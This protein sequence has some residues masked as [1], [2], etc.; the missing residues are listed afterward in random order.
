MDDSS[1]AANKGPGLDKQPT[2]HPY[3]MQEIH[4]AIPKHCTQPSTLRSLGVI[5]RDLLLIFIIGCMATR[6]SSLT[7]PI[8]RF[9]AWSLYGFCQGLFF[10]GLWELAHE[11]GHRAL[12]KDKWVND[13][14]GL[15]VHSSLLVP[16]HSWRFT[17][18]THHKSTNHMDRDIAFVPQVKDPAQADKRTGTFEKAID[19]VA[20][21]PAAA[22]ATLFVHQLVAF[23]LYLTINNFALPQIRAAPLYKRSHFYT[24]GDGPN[25]KPRHTRAIII[26]DL[27]ISVSFFVLWL[28]TRE[29]GSW[30]IFRFYGLPY[31]WVNHWIC[32]SSP[33]SCTEPT[34]ACEERLLLT[35]RLCWLVTITF[36]QHNDVSVPYYSAKSWSFIRGAASTIDRDFGFIGRYIFHGAIEY[37]VL[38][39]QVSGVPCYHGAEA[40]AA[41][42]PVMGSYYHSDTDTPYPLAF[43]KNYRGCQLVSESEV[44]AGVF[45]F[46]PIN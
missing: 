26:S 9:L 45:V 37:H 3:T 41:I 10:T 40:T 22:L 25:F 15:V 46:D 6:I 7:S 39:H 27:A 33:L 35:A 13:L 30:T 4:E 5:G 29:F 36:L 23:P 31:L 11:C 2:P 44:D 14:I 34:Y 18:Q 43:W 24:G 21:C 12:S 19:L 38:H 32:K 20:D 1:E 28:A 8:V 17:H 16:F 42:R